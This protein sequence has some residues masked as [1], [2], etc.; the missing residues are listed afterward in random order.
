MPSFLF[1]PASPNSVFKN[2]PQSGNSSPRLT[3][4]VC[5]SYV[6]DWRLWNRSELRGVPLTEN[7]FQLFEFYCW[8]RL[9]TWAV[10]QLS[11]KSN[12]SV[13][14]VLSGGS[15]EALELLQCREGEHAGG[16]LGWLPV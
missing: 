7:F 16:R 15:Q 5:R 3:R 10:Y 12:L 13:A 1:S 9:A 11:D 6:P 14:S 8:H 2:N 4:G